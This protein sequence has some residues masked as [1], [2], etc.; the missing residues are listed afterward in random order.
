MG[1]GLDVISK[2]RGHV[3]TNP[4]SAGVK[5]EW[6]MPS[7][8]GFVFVIFVCICVLYLFYHCNI[9]FLYSS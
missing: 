6:K 9:F 3:N 4:L 8:R 2:F 7:E 1:G 5:C